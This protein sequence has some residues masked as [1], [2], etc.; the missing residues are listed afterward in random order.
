VAVSVL[1]VDDEPLARRGVVSRLSA[2]P[3][4]RVVAESDS[5]ESALDA[6]SE[7][8]PDLIFL[9]IHMPGM[10][11]FDVLS[12]LP[13]NCQG[14]FIFLTAYDRYALKA[15]EVHAFDYLLK[16][17]DDER[18]VETVS[19]ARRLLELQ[20]TEA[21]HDRLAP[22]LA[23][24]GK[25]EAPVYSERFAIRNGRN[26]QFVAASDVDWIEAL[27]DYAGL[28]V[29]K[30]THLLREPLRLLEERLNPDHFVRVHRSSIVRL[31]RIVQLEAMHN[32]D[33]ILHLKSGDK[34]KVSRTYGDRVRELLGI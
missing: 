8:N 22:L 20:K 1:I 14:L 19:R 4:F 13:R 2:F 17:I 21:L 23:T 9:D 34:L 5:G 6:I 30:H 27:G 16:P 29:G 3:D 25:S 24:L 28:H 11:G 26:T 15:F 12:N 31:D 18:F 7:H 33:A 32:Q 10:S